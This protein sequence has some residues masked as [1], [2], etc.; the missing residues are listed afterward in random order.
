MAIKIDIV[1][2]YNDREVNRAIND[3]KLLHSQGGTTSGGLGKL[4]AAGLAMGASLGLAAAQAVQAGAAMALQFG[5]DSVNAFIADDAAAQSLAQTFEQLGLATQSTGVES[6]IAKTETAAAVADDQLRPALDRLVRSTH[7][8]QQAQ[9]LLGLALDI[10]AKRHVSLETASNAVGKA[11]D[12]NYGALAKLAGGYTTAELKAMGLNSVVSTLSSQFAGSATAAA[13]TY[14]GQLALLGI[15]F[16]NIQESFGKGF[17]DGVTAS[18]GGA[19]GAGEQL[20]PVMES[21]AANAESLG[22]SIGS[23]ASNITP[24]IAGIKVMW[25]AFSVLDAGLGS[26]IA[27]MIALTFAMR[28]DFAAASA[29]VAEADRKLLVASGA[30]TTATQDLTQGTVDGIPVTLSAASALD[31]QAAAANRAANALNDKTRAEFANMSKLDNLSQDAAG[32]KASANQLLQQ[33]INL[34][35]LA[36]NAKNTY[37]GSA[38]GAAEKI[39]ILTE[40]QQNLALTMAGTQVA[41]KQVTDE[42]DSLKKASDD[43]AAS[44]TGAIKGTVDLSAAFTAAQKA[45]QEGTLAAGESVVSTTIANFRAQILAAKQFSDSLTNVAAAGGSQALIDQILAVAATQG[46][47]AGEYLA[48]TLVIDGLVPEL[49]TQLASFNVFATEAGQAMSDNFYGQG[50]MSA[51]SLLN[52][53]STEV[54]AQQKMLDRLGKNIGLPIAAAISEEIA[55]AI[56]DGIADGHAVAARRRAEAAAAASFEPITVMPGAS[57]ASTTGAGNN[58][59]GIATFAA[60]GSVMGGVP[61]I[62]GEKGPELFVPGSNGSIVPNRGGSPV[63]G[64]SYSITVQAGVGDPRAIG[65]SIVEYVKKFEQAN[66]PVFRA[67]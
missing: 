67:A 16:G 39:V 60:G 37:G 58:Y 3:L 15:Q 36:A 46:P 43:Y 44:I 35:Q 17:L 64:N 19:K 63:G 47:G 29:I 51:V 9:D 21:L 66:G 56:R 11:V 34:D 65:Q 2:D 62:V 12:G 38:A 31:E 30:L 24:A 49:T 6:F 45:S 54:A 53:L 23:L 4:G 5:V 7:D 32:R 18:M 26:V 25:G 48:N 57:S 10:S 42:L 50:I 14:Q 61:I 1:G 41:V 8:V 28:G 27:K 20:T 22:R 55:Q 59:G 13:G 40:K 33:Q 52:G